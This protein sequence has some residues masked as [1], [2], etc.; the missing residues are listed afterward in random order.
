[1]GYRFRYQR[2]SKIQ[3]YVSLIHGQQFFFF[4]LGLTLF[5]ALK[6]V[7]AFSK[8]RTAFPWNYMKIPKYLFMVVD[9]NI[10]YGGGH[11]STSSHWYK[12]QLSQQSKCKRKHYRIHQ[13]VSMKVC[14]L[15]NNLNFCM[16]LNW[17]IVLVV[18][19]ILLYFPFRKME[20]KP[21]WF[22]PCP[23]W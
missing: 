5:S 23:S 11:I 15:F 10:K 6:N 4:F 22:G 14:D 3:Q 9:I 21:Q 1:M 13:N 18:R 2:W 7:C 12:I 8:Y 20:L 17:Y 16:V 19:L